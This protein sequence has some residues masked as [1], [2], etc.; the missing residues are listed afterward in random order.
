[1]LDRLDDVKELVQ[2]LGVINYYYRYIPNLVSLAQYLFARLKKTEPGHG[3]Q[4]KT[5]H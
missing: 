2:L 4:P 1:M 5:K 3:V